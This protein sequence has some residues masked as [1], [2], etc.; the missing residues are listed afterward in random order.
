MN[1]FSYH[2]PVKV[3]FGKGTI[4]GLSNAIPADARVLVT[5]GG[6]SIKK[7][8]VHKQVMDALKGRATFEFG[9]IEA[10]P[11]YETLIKAVEL[12]KGEK[13]GFLLAVGGGS[14]IDGT[15]FIAAAARYA[16]GDPWDILAKNAAVEDAVPLGTVLTLPATGSEMNCL[17]VVSRDATQEKLHFASPLVYPRFSILDPEVTYSL[18]KRQLANGIVDTFTHVMEQYA[19]QDINTPLQDRQALA[20]IE[21]LVEIAPKILSDR[22]DYDARAGLMWC[23]THA[24]NG[25]LSCGTETDWSTHMI[26]HELTAFFGIDH[27][28]SLAIVLPGVW[29]HQIFNKAPR[30]AS[31]GKAIWGLDQI[32]ALERARAAIEKTEIFFLSLGVGTRLID[33]G[34]KE[35]GVEKIVSRFKERG[36]RLGE[37]K[38]IGADEIGQI[39]RLRL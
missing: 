35:D 27:A 14:V 15:K 1:N 22:M 33:Y 18:P 12:V 17:A 6:G 28:Q 3:I 13:I 37:L 4:K 20:I 26:G 11:R 32:N 2:N 24:L 5:Y 29:E 25:L 31:Y 8:G 36:T 34:I 39:L 7:N 30:L 10:N 23:A 16:K 19:T 38:N 9:G 21:T